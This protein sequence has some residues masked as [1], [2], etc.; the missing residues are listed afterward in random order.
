MRREK[1][2][3]IS[4][5]PIPKVIAMKPLPMFLS[6]V[7]V[8][9]LQSCT[10]SE[11]LPPPWLSYSST[12]SDGVSYR[13]EYDWDTTQGSVFVYAEDGRN[14]RV[15]VTTMRREALL[16]LFTQER[17]EIYLTDSDNESSEPIPSC[18]GS[19]VRAQTLC[20]ALELA[21]ERAFVSIVH[22]ED[23]LHII[24]DFLF[25]Q[26]TTMSFESAEML[27]FLNNM[28]IEAIGQ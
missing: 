23:E 7:L 8:L 21:K 14:N 12:N 1:P 17:L 13:L 10:T 11:P 4:S 19:H 15:P 28:T 5:R 22:P 24:E 25:M 3:V 2:L 9:I 18:P 26:P 27:V 20:S 16:N 6:L